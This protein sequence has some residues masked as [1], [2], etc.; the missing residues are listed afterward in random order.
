V[1]APEAS[2]T[3]LIVYVAP[4]LRSRATQWSEMAGDERRR[5]AMAAANAHDAGALAELTV[6]YLLL[7]GRQHAAASDHTIRSYAVG[8]RRLLLEWESENIL[9]PSQD[10]G[11]RY[12]ASLSMGH[13]PATC[14]ARLAAAAALYRALQWARATSSSPFVG[15]T[16]PRNR[17]PRHERRHPY[18]D[19]QV[20]AIASSADSRLR[21]LILLTAHGGL[22]IAE[23]LSLR[24]DDVHLAAGYLRVEHGKGGKA[25]TVYLSHTLT[26]ALEDA[27]HE[28]PPAAA[29]VV[30]TADGQAAV[31]PS[32]LRRRLRLACAAAGVE[33]LGWHA[34]RHTAGTRLARETGNLQL[35]AG[36]LGHADVSTAAIYAKWSETALAAQVATW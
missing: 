12:I 14:S 36:H 24:W 10:A 16:A 6:A 31:D 34:F 9:H 15:V 30:L 35:V 25:R 2:S 17:T 1:E 19:A 5:G 7:H 11:D 13:A 4:G 18:S 23:A 8:V 32:W 20:E 21:L 28:Q 29:G 3:D 22:R 26:L 33:Y 27:A